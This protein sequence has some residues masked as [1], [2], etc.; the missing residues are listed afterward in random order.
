MEAQ[1][2]RHP[3]EGNTNIFG[4]LSAAVEELEQATATRRHIV[5]L[6][7]DWSSSGAYEDLLAPMAAANITLSAVGAGGGGD[8]AFLSALAK[9]GGGRYHPATNPASIPDIFLKETQQ[10]S[11]Q[12]IVEESFSIQTGDSPILRRLDAGLPRLL[13]YNGTTPKPTAGLQPLL[14]PAR[15]LDLARRGVGRAGGRVPGGRR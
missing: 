7:D 9:Q 1:I 4:G 11:G 6:T 2:A 10:V 3:P 13:G 8:G 5:L 14:Q 15:V 12:N